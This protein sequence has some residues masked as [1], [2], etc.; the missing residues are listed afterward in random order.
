M[1]TSSSRDVKLTLQVDTLGEDGIKELQKAVEAL[2]ATA[3]Q[4]R[5]S[6]K[7]LPTRSG[8]SASRAKRCP[9]SAN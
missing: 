1:A 8:V 9:H 3:V 7:N 4:R 6:S 5:L 2:G